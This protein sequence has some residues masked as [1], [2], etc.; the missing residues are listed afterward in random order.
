ML[1]FILIYLLLYARASLIH[2][3]QSIQFCDNSS[4]SSYN[5]LI[6]FAIVSHYI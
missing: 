4:L 3:G 6:V 2:F 5:I 1:Y